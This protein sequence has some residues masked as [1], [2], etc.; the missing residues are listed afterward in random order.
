MR[1]LSDNAGY[2]GEKQ[3]ASLKAE[4][5]TCGYNVSVEFTDVTDNATVGNATYFGGQGQYQALDAAYDRYV[6]MTIY[7]LNGQGIAYTDETEKKTED[8]T[9][10]RICAP[11]TVMKWNRE[12]DLTPVF[13]DAGSGNTVGVY[14]TVYYS[15][16]GGS[17]T[18]IFR[19]ADN[20]YIFTPMVKNAVY[21]VRYTGFQ[22]AC[23]RFAAET[24]ADI[25]CVAQKYTVTYFDGVETKTKQVDE[26]DVV[27]VSD[28]FSADVAGKKC[29][30]ITIGDK[31]YSADYSFTANEDVSVMPKFVEMTMKQGASI[32]L[33]DDGTSGIRFMLALSK[34]DYDAINSLT[35]VKFYYSVTRV[36]TNKTITQEIVA[37]KNVYDETEGIYK[38]T[39]AIINL[40]QDMFTVEWKA[41]VFFTADYEDGTA[42]QTTAASNDN[43]RS[44][45]QV[46]LLV[47]NSSDF[48]KYS[49]WQKEIIESYIVSEA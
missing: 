23:G 34:A 13:Y 47:K 16:N 26:G 15:V 9:N 8:T 2:T 40:T 44:I 29:I 49:Q 24:T 25:E 33:R 7:L 6:D 11:V 37:E 32:R 38:L 42:V 18:E 4:D 14:V 48:S 30:G 39:A 19:N 43:V 27:K 17:Y 28:W 41:S 3:A 21:T 35:N 36:D 10:P 22:D 12:V 5:F 1:S 20:R 46:A 45:S 31:T